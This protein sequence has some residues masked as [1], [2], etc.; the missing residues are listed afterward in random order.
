MVAN[1]FTV[2]ESGPFS[3]EPEAFVKLK[4]KAPDL[5]PRPSAFGGVTR[6][7]GLGMGLEVASEIRFG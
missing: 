7:T 2:A 4:L 1:G 3:F 6:L 5:E